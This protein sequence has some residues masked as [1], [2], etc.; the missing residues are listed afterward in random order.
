M[1]RPLTFE[2]A[3][4]LQPGDTLYHTVFKNS[5]GT[6]QRWKVNGQV[7]TWKTDPNRIR[8]PLKHGMYAYDKIDESDFTLDTPTGS[9]AISILSLDEN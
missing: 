7:K 1:Q 5:D 6:P 8:V 2:Q 9:V 3:L 4:E